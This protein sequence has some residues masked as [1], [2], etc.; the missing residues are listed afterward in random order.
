MEI[1]CPLAL[2]LFYENLWLECNLTVHEVVVQL[3]CKQKSRLPNNNHT[4]M[5]WGCWSH[6]FPL[7]LLVRLSW[8]KKHRAIV[9]LSRR[10]KVVLSQPDSSLRE[11]MLK[12]P[13]NCNWAYCNLSNN[14]PDL[15][16]LKLE[17][18]PLLPYWVNTQFLIALSISTIPFFTHIN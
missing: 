15:W 14:R 9:Y 1:I 10:N 16:G 18:A 13:H 17:I 12:R 7:K 8:A 4:I 2:S 6:K 3:N 5:V 11:P